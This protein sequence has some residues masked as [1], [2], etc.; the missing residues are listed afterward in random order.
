MILHDVDVYSEETCDE[1]LWEFWN[2]FETIILFYIVIFEWYGIR[3]MFA[4][5]RIR[6]DIWHFIS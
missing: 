1:N 3:I 2:V 4:S 6:D 5:V